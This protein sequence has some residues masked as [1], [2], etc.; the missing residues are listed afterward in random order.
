MAR[1]DIA[2]RLY[3][4]L[5]RI[6]K[7]LASSSRLQLVVLLAQGERTVESLARAIGLPMA[8]VSHHLQTLREARLVEAR[9]EGLYV[10]Y[11]LA[12]SDVFELADMLRRVGEHRLAEMDRIV[13]HY[14]GSR[15]KLEPVRMEEL[16]KRVKDGRAIVLDVRPQEEF[17]H[18]HIAG[19]ISVPLDRLKS[20]LAKL[21]KRKEIIA[22]CRGP[23]CVM[24]FKAV[25]LLR[26]QGHRA[27]RLEEGFPEWR[28]AGFPVAVGTASGGRSARAPGG[29]ERRRRVPRSRRSKG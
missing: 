17:G 12:G 22:Y 6:A 15:D 25:R 26:A 28:V 19:A 3:S 23:Y 9:K 24:A 14:L 2:L 10:H 7:A 5:T 18:G 13:K 29:R 4:E 8:N 27:R 1:E 20:R 21:P 16:L 11:R